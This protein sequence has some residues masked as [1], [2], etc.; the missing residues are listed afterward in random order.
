MQLRTKVL[1]VALLVMFTIDVV[2]A[3]ADG[4]PACPTDVDALWDNCTGVYEPKPTSEFSGDIYR[5]GF[6]ADVFHGHGGY[7]YKNGEVFFGTYVDGRLEGPGMY[8][9]GLSLIHI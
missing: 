6:K 4:L 7:F 9:Y 1:F 8:I 2:K 5:G 3:Q